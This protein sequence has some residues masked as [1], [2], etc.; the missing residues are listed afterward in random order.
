MIGFFGLS[1]L[2]DL[3]TTSTAFL[4]IWCSLFLYSSVI[5]DRSKS[6]SITSTWKINWCHSNKY[7]IKQ[8]HKQ[9]NLYYGW[10]CSLYKFT[11]VSSTYRITFRDFNR[12]L[13]KSS[14]M[15]KRG[16]FIGRFCDFTKQSGINLIK[17]MRFSREIMKWIQHKK[18]LQIMT[19]QI[20]S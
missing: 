14:E 3:M 11:S 17:W 1:L 13:N 10:N 18:V 8:S 9:I 4:R 5:W 19:F 15:K 6:A 16:M 20:T 7:Y 2:G 12:S